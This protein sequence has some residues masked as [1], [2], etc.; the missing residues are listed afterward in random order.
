MVS[1]FGP[2]RG[3]AG[4]ASRPG[5]GRQPTAVSSAFGSILEAIGIPHWD[6]AAAGPGPR[7]GHMVFSMP[8][9][10][11]R[12]SS[13]RLIGVTCLRSLGDGHVN[14]LCR[15]QYRWDVVKADDY[16][17]K[18]WLERRLGEDFVNL[19]DQFFGPFNGLLAYSYLLQ[20]MLPPTN[21]R[22]SSA[23]ALRAP[24]C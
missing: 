6:R 14:S 15:M 5:P 3:P 13:D 23:I 21:E 9:K 12:G 4:F 16:G 18:L 20:E 19:L 2:L 10:S 11:I 8:Q 24:R 1:P 17:V 22:A 7:H